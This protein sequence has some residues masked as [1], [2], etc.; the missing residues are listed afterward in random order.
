MV[1]L[2]PSI[3]FLD[4]A[5]S[6]GDDRRRQLEGGMHGLDASDLV[7]NGAASWRGALTER[8]NR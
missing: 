6:D 8:G 5:A 2:R 7:E 3:L 4:C 1:A